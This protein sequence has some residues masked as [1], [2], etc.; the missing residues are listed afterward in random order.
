MISGADSAHDLPEIALSDGHS[1]VQDR[2]AAGRFTIC[3]D[4]QGLLRQEAAT[5]GKP[6]HIASVKVGLRDLEGD[7]CDVY[8][9]FGDLL[10]PRSRSQS[11][12]STAAIQR[13]RPCASL[14]R[15]FQGRGPGH[16]SYRHKFALRD[17]VDVNEPNRPDG[18]ARRGRA[19]D[20]T[21]NEERSR[22][23]LICEPRRQMLFDREGIRLDDRLRIAPT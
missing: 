11:C 23:S 2:K 9:K 15:V 12:N 20:R 1:R 7:D 18:E 8:R 10:V 4:R 6:R 3:S 13:A 22:R 21:R 16:A 19:R 17:V 14:R 5:G